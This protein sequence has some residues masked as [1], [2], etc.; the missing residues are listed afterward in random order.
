MP[1]TKLSHNAPFPCGSGKTYGASCRG[2]GFGWG[3]DEAGNVYRSKPTT[4][5]V[6]EALGGSFAKRPSLGK[7]GGRGRTTRPSPRCRPPSRCREQ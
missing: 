3:K 1:R 6:R 5:E 7:A 4:P 2:K